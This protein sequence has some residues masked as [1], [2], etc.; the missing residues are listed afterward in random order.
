MVGLWISHRAFFCVCGN[1]VFKMNT[2][3]CCHLCSGSFLFLD[4]ALFDVRQFLSLSFSAT[5]PLRWW[6][7]PMIYVCRQPRQLLLWIHLT[8]WPFWLHTLQLHW[9]QQTV[10]SENLTI[11]H[12]ALLSHEPS[13]NTICNALTLALHSVNK[14]KN[15]E[16]F[17]QLMFFQCSQNKQFY[18]YVVKFFHYSILHSLW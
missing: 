15:N 18:S 7:L 6:R 14:Q 1:G 4:T 3:F 13:V 16:R 17:S 8:K 2:E 11:S 12:F 9:H 5:I 10:L